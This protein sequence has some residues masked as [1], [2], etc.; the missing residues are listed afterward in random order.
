M[1]VR[2]TDE[3]LEEQKKL[4]RK[5]KSAKAGRNVVGGAS[6]IAIILLLL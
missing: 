1:Y 6:G 2:Q 5:V 3:L 4:K